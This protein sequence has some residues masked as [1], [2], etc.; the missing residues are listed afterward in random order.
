MTGPL[1]RDEVR[2]AL[3]GRPARRPA[4]VPLGQRTAARVAQVPPEVLATD[5]ALLAT[6]LDSA[7]RLFGYDAIVVGFD[8]AAEAEVVTEAARR[9]R[10]VRGDI[11]VLGVVGAPE[12]PAGRAGAVALARALGEAGVDALLVHHWSPRSHDPAALRTLTRVAAH[13]ECVLAR[14]LS[15]EDP[16]ERSD[17]DCPLAP[18]RPLTP[19]EDAAAPAA[20]ARIAGPDFTGAGRAAWLTTTGDEAAEA[21]PEHLHATVA[22]VGRAAGH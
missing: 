7:Q 19:A 9:I 3:R 13:Y 1:T 20:V 6:T 16:L 2:E 15:P 22:A 10:A 18:G 4:F 11:A 21:T 5:P 12:P 17:V 14:S 8:P